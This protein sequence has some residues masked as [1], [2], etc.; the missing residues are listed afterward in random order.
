MGLLVWAPFSIVFFFL[1]VAV[2]WSS[3]A[4]R[5][6]SHGSEGGLRGDI[7]VLMHDG[8]CGRSVCVWL[9]LC[10]SVC[11]SVCIVACGGV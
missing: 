9:C 8:E 5:E 1:V 4:E 2:R 10:M 6:L 3:E 11:K 7:L